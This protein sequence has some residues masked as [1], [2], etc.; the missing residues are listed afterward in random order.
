[1]AGHER[2]LEQAVTTRNLPLPGRL[3][4]AIAKAALLLDLGDIYVHHAH[5]WGAVYGPEMLL[6]LLF[7]GYAIGV[8]RSHNMV[9]A[10]CQSI[11][12]QLLAGG[13]HPDHLTLAHSQRSFCVEIVDLLAQVLVIAHQLGRSRLGIISVDSSRTHADSSYSHAVSYGRLLMLERSLRI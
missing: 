1:V 4:R 11:S 5:V 3:P 10:T 7:Y 12:F 8:P 13:W 9:N 6:G 2:A